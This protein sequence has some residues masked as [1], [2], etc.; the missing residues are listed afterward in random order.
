MTRREYFIFIIENKQQNTTGT[1][2]NVTCNYTRLQLA[3]KKQK[4]IMKQIF[5]RVTVWKG[6]NR[7]KC[8]NHIE[9]HHKIRLQSQEPKMILLFLR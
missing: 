9:L 4:H 5:L 7:E 3:A 8:I 2:R 1:F 6:I